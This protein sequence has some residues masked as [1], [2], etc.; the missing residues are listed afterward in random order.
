[1]FSRSRCLAPLSRSAGFVLPAIILAFAGSAFAKAPSIKALKEKI[2]SVERESE[3]LPDLLINP[4]PWS[5]GYRSSGETKADQPVTIDLWFI[6]P[7]PID[8]IALLPTSRSPTSGQVAAFGFPERFKIERLLKDGSRE[9]IVDYSRQD[10]MVTGIEPRL[11]HL[12][13]PVFADGIR[14]TVLRHAKNPTWWN[15]QFVTTLGEVFAFSGDWNVAL[16]AK[17]TTTSAA[18]Y[19]YLWAPEGLVDGFSIFSPVSGD[20]DSPFDNFYYPG[21]ELT[22][23]FDL[24]EVQSVDEFR[25]WPV[26]HTSQHHFPQASGI[27]FPTQIRLERID[28]PDATTGQ[29]LY[30]SGEDPPRA[31]SGPYM[32]RFP[33]VQGRYFRLTLRDPSPDFRADKPP[34]FALSE[35]E[36]LNQG[37]VLT[38]D[39]PPIIENRVKKIKGQPLF[40][41]R[42]PKKIQPERLVDG[43]TTEGD[44]LPLRPWIE[45]LSR[46]ALL[47]RQ[48]NDLRLDL[49]IAQQLERKRL[50]SIILFSACI[51]PILI[52]LAKLMADRRWKRI[53]DR[54]ACDL[55][56][57]IGANASSLVHMTELIKESVREPTELQTQ[58]LDEAIYT[59]RLTSGE[60]RNFIQLLEADKSGFDLSKQ[61]ERIA[62][63]I[64]GTIE[65]KCD[66]ESGTPLKRLPI[67]RQWD[68]LL[69]FKEALN[70]IVKHA[71]A[72]YVEILVYRQGGRIQVT[73]SDNGKGIPRNLLPRHLGIRAKSLKANLDIESAPDQGTRIQLSFK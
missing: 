48:L 39:R 44:I 71:A 32:L 5:L 55:H 49:R 2:A 72:T 26:A 53:R 65:Y 62:R 63:Q 3:S 60:T 40:P 16:N 59:A 36:I 37:K 38:R 22:L 45:G 28:G 7:A 29:L 47:D 10:Y 21:E 11:F 51:T 61:I 30:Q 19:G 46:R 18:S 73:I 68:L 43:T 24:G 15:Y 70:N 57:E 17:V 66:I 64:L 52:W 35:I 41:N 31:G 1:M 69:F 4:T 25:L 13:E 12:T 9:V 54:I 58:M 27:D 14:I 42:A 23:R 20:F 34:Q 6:T 56:D 33:A 50:S 67:S 8:L